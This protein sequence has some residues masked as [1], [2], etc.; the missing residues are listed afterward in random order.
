[1][2]SLEQ[3]I[4]GDNF[5]KQK[6]TNKKTVCLKF[7][8]TNQKKMEHSNNKTKQVAILNAVCGTQKKK[9]QNNDITYCMIK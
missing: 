9:Q 3:F 6:Q 8:L 4:I 2:I 5:E 1:M 7:S